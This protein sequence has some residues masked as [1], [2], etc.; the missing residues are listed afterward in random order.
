MEIV[1]K[2]IL[3]FFILVLVIYSLQLSFSLSKNVLKSFDTARVQKNIIENISSNS[4]VGSFS[5]ANNTYNDVNFELNP[6]RNIKYNVAIDRLLTRTTG[7][8]FPY[9]Y[10]FQNTYI[11]SQNTNNNL[12]ETLS[13]LNNKHINFISDNYGTSKPLSMAIFD[14]IKFKS[15]N[16]KIIAKNITFLPRSNIIELNDFSYLSNNVMFFF[17]KL[18]FNKI[19][20]LNYNDISF[21]SSCDEKK[22]NIAKELSK[23]LPHSINKELNLFKKTKSIPYSIFDSSEE[24]CFYEISASDF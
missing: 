9:F 17:K 21:F 3:R 13:G 1:I 8:K 20:I 12:I 24:R 18:K 16:Q 6:K 2:Y 14:N 4:K 11:S 7:E 15:P 19:K 22:I 23:I 10:L 5:W